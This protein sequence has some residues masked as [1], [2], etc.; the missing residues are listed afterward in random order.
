M[1][2]DAGSV[3]WRVCSVMREVW[4]VKCGVE[5]AKCEVNL[6]VWTAKCGVCVDACVERERGVM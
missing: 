2:F 3:E 5:S 6:R 4:C 1:Q